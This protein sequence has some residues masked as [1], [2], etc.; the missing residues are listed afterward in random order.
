MRL[1][2]LTKNDIFGLDEIMMDYKRRVSTVECVSTEGECLFLSKENFMNCVHRF[3]FY[4]HVLD[5]FF[6]KKESYKNRLQETH[7]F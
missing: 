5:E 1:T 6:L 2:I 7:I 4:D 3:E